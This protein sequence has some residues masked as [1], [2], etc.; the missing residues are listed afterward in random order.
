VKTGKVKLLLLMGILFFSACS[1]PQG[2]DNKVAAPLEPV[3]RIAVLPVATSAVA[4]E[5]M[6]YQQANDLAKGAELAT[7]IINDTLA[8]NPKV[9]LLTESQLTT[10]TPEISGGL[11]G[12]ITTIGQ[13]LNCDAVLVTQI[14]RFKQRVGSE[15]ASEEP[16]SAAFSMVLYGTKKKVVLWSADFRETQESLLSNIFSFEKVQ[17]RGLKWISVEALLEQ[18]LKERLAQC[19]YLHM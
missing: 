8:G 19:P 7:R 5:S 2:K 3:A 12:A 1:L 17:K 11:S 13:K 18:G 9:V 14:Q 10:L 16:A 15:F 6:G 4:D